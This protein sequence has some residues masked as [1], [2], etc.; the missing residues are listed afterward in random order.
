MAHAG[1][2]SFAGLMTVRF[3]LGALEACVAPGF[4]LMT[5]LFYKRNEQPLR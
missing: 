1:C 3:L 2:H 5:G 4:G